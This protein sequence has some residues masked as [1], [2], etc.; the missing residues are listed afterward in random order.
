MTQEWYSTSITLQFRKDGED[1][2]KQQVISNIAS[3]ASEGDIDALGEALAT[4][5]DGLHYIGA[6]K[7]N[8]DHIHD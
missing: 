4:L 7:T 5:D 8:K 3:D 1:K 6:M 2:V